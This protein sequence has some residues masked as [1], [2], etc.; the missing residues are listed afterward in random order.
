MTPPPPPPLAYPHYHYRLTTSYIHALLH[1]VM[2]IVAAVRPPLTSLDPYS[3]THPHF[4]R[5]HP[6]THAPTH[7]PTY[8]RHHHQIH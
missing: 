6:P 3:T 5:T 2:T 4:G 1:F 8:Y 7:P